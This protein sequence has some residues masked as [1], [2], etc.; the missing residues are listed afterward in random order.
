MHKYGTVN[1][2]NDYVR[3]KKTKKEM[4][5]TLLLQKEKQMKPTSLPFSRLPVAVYSFVR[6]KM[7]KW[8]NL[9]FLHCKH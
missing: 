3:R 4:K 1:N 6:K 2:R 5:P 9:L 8:G 7:K